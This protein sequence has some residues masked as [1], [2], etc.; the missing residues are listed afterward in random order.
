MGDDACW[1]SRV[2]LECGRFLDEGR[3]EEQTCPHC[4]AELVPTDTPAGP[5][6]TASSPVTGGTTRR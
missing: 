4:G 6:P 3:T 5:S 1:L 2:C